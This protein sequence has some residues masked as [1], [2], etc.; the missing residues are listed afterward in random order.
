MFFIIINLSLIFNIGYSAIDTQI[1]IY[2]TIPTY[3]FYPPNKFEIQAHNYKIL[4]LIIFIHNIYRNN[5]S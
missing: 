5:C 2:T 3:L 4:N 1:K